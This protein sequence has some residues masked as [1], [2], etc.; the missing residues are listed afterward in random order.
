[1]GENVDIGEM[2]YKT[3]SA[4]NNDVYFY[5]NA[6]ATEASLAEC[7]HGLVKRNT[8]F[9]NIFLSIRPA[10]NTET[11][12]PSTR[13]FYTPNNQCKKMT[14]PQLKRLIAGFQPR[15]PGLASGQACGVCGGQSG[16]GAGFL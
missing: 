2:L 4:V 3:V 1:V 9:T 5:E 7:K 15:W 12:I 11:L 16:T 14:V 13:I 8:F 10:R 6:S